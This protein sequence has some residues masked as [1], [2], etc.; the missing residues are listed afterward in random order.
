MI[1]YTQLFIE[2]MC[3]KLPVIADVEL[4]FQNAVQKALEK[5]MHMSKISIQVHVSA[6][7]MV[8]IIDNFP[9]YLQLKNQVIKGP[10]SHANEYVLNKFVEK[11]K[12][13]I[14]DLYKQKTD[15]GE[16]YYIDITY[17]LVNIECRI[18]SVVLGIINNMV[19]PEYMKWSHDS[20]KWIRPIRRLVATYDSM[21][22]VFFVAG[23]RSSSTA[24]YYLTEPDEFAVTSAHNYFITLEQ[25]KIYIDFHKRHDFVLRQIKSILPSK[26]MINMDSEDVIVDIVRSCESPFIHLG[27]FEHNFDLPQDIIRH[28]MVYH[29]KYIPVYNEEGAISQYF[30]VHANREIDPS[31]MIYGAE[32]ALYARLQE[33][34]RFWQKDLSRT[35]EEYVSKLYKYS[36]HPGL[37][38]LAQ[39]T[40]RL[41]FISN[42][43]FSP[44]ITEAASYVNLDLVMDTIYE[45]PDLHGI[46]S[47]LYG[48]CKYNISQSIVNTIRDS[49]YPQ[50][51]G[52]LSRDISQSA[53]SLGF[54][55]RL[56][57]LV[58]FFG[59]D[60]IPSGSSDVFGLRRSAFG[61]LHLGYYLTN[62]PN[63]PNMINHLINLYKDQ[64]IVLAASTNAVLIDFL[65]KRLLALLHKV[66]PESGSLFLLDTITWN[67]IPRAKI[68]LEY[69][70]LLPTLT[71]L[72]RRISGL[73]LPHVLTDL[74]VIN[75]KEHDLITNL[76]SNYSHQLT[77]EPEFLLNLAGKT[78]DLLDHV[79]IKNLAEDSR[80][81]VLNTIAHVRNI[82]KNYYNL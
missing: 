39:Q 81:I 4:T 48:Q 74:A 45:I 3:E 25:K 47:S 20:P 42:S 56:D 65:K 6:Y 44:D 64:G 5:Y 68:A 75:I 18:D 32:K 61:L 16:F 34:D 29:Q 21:P 10:N 50:Y 43:Y 66:S 12:K 77:G 62:K 63:L 80:V 59:L 55:T 57:H 67:E 8:C 78:V 36:F 15:S 69:P 33:S 70:H 31:L 24:L 19:W 23:L 58:G 41:E 76:I 40:A 14:E 27:K 28:T 13:Q 35:K 26:T 11:Y 53:A 2:I 17:D 22:L 9:S 72:F 60:L 7:R 30:L 46:M 49:I 52:G 1:N 37:G 79:T 54:I 51:E 82:I 73:K 71:A 38:S